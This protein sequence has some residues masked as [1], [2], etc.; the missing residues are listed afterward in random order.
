[1]VRISAERVSFYEDLLLI[2]HI[3]VMFI[4]LEARLRHRVCRTEVTAAER[5]TH[6]RNLLQLEPPCR[7]VP[8]HAV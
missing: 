4:Q 5:R 3:V 2:K 1:M 8:A 7:V 6:K